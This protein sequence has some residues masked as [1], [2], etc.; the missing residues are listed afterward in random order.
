MI[1]RILKV[2]QAKMSEIYPCHYSSTALISVMGSF[3]AV[4]F[5]LCTE[6]DW[7]QWKL[8]WNLR[9]LTVAYMVLLFNSFTKNTLIIITLI[10]RKTSLYLI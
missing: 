8:T 7:T 6:R 9:L 1:V 3:Q 10:L 2:L 4:A 5:A